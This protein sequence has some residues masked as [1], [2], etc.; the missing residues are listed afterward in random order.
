MWFSSPAFEA[1]TEPF[2]VLVEPRMSA[3]TGTGRSLSGGF[4][5]SR[6]QA[7]SIPPSPL[8]SP[9]NLC[10]RHLL[11]GPVAVPWRLRSRADEPTRPD[12]GLLPVDLSKNC[13]R[14]TQ[15]EAPRQR[16]HRLARQRALPCECLSQCTG[17]RHP[18]LPDVEREVRYA[19]FTVQ[20]AK[21]SE[22]R[23]VLQSLVGSNC[24]DDR[25]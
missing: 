22:N 3:M 14:Q 19:P 5:R 25:V 23:H 13:G 9:N 7:I 8:Q 11:A 20:E 17:I 12:Q 24:G 6:Y 18:H 10:H 1:T 15:V 2:G 4:W 16:L 21:S